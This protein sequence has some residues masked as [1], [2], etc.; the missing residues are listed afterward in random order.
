MDV[1]TSDDASA[2]DPPSSRSS[3]VMV[4]LKK[5]LRVDTVTVGII[6][7]VVWS[8]LLLPIIFYYIP[9]VVSSAQSFNF[10]IYY[11]NANCILH[12]VLL[13]N[14]YLIPN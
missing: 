9:V 8:L 11:Q 13:N 1:E 5:W 6:L 4:K 14:I 12:V 7:V 3:C 10:T 2:I